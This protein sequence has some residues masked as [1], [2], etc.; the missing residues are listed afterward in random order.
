M[1]FTNQSIPFWFEKYRK[2]F[3]TIKTFR[4]NFLNILNT[5]ILKMVFNIWWQ[6]FKQCYSKQILYTLYVNFEKNNKKKGVDSLCADRVKMST[7]SRDDNWIQ[8]CRSINRN[9]LSLINLLIVL[10]CVTFWP[11]PWRCNH[12]LN[13]TKQKYKVKKKQLMPSVA[14]KPAI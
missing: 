6:K 1:N 13:K 9:L 10:Q 3:K 4:N 2:Q 7:W 14:L 11:V 8:N 5:F 12:R